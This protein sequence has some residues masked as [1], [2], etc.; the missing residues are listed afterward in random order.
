MSNTE[1][2]EEI[3][4]LR[5][6]INDHREWT[7]GVYSV[8]IDL[9]PFLLRG[10]PVMA[11]QLGKRWRQVAER[12]DFITGSGLPDE[13]DEPPERM[14]LRKMLYRTLVVAGSWPGQTHG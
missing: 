1:L 14:E 4:Q 5:A 7:D 12:Y 9:L 13:N 8:L 6:E 10:D 2:R 11:E 3:A